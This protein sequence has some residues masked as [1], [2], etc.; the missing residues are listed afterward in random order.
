MACLIR[1]SL[2]TFRTCNF[3]GSICRTIAM[4][5]KLRAEEALEEL[6]QKNPYYEKYASKLAALQQASP[7]EF[8]NRFDSVGKEHNPPGISKKER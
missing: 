5:A 3:Q 8:L 2:N 4:S 1:K 7:A 6:K